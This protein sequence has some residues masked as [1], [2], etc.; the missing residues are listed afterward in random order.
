MIPASPTPRELDLAAEVARLEKINTVLMDRAER[1][2]SVQASSFSLFQTTV[3]L[4]QHIRRRT[5]ELEE[6]LHKNEQTNRALR[7]AEAMFHGIVSQSLV[8]IALITDG[9]ITY[10]N[11]K[12]EEIFGLGAGEAVGLDPM[13]LAAESDRPLVAKN[14][15]ARMSGDVDETAYTFRGFRRDGAPLYVEVY[16]SAL[17]VDDQRIMVSVFLDITERIRVEREIQAL[18]A[19]LREQSTHDA[20]TGLYNR[21]YFEEAL[22][23]ELVVAKRSGH[24]VTVVMADLDFFKAVNDTFGH[25]AGDEVLKTFGEWM[26]R[27]SRASDFCFR[28]GGEE[29]LLVLPHMSLDDAANRA[30]Q[31]RA[32][33]ATSGVVCDGVKIAITASF[34]IASFPHDGTTIDQLVN[35][36]DARLY[37]AKAS[38]RN[39][40]ISTSE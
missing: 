32:A 30:E 29:F 26:R 31:L 25:L 19:T 2:T 24:P 11:P 16:G 15:R 20:L 21:R 10:A 12:M 6:A 33:F 17:Q 1:S 8:G 38:G 9:Q 39:R 27:S 14:V 22:G 35:A 23:R 4:E 40:V 13:E 34:G 37:V 28:W 18:Q 3:M 7:A 5:A 36:A